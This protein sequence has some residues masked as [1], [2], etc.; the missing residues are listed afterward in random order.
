MV[1]IFSCVF[2]Q[3][4]ESLKC[5]NSSLP[6]TSDERKV[7]HHVALPFCFVPTKPPCPV[8]SGA[9]IMDKD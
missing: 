2:L 4:S 5:N 9:G 1:G 7:L 6:V 3:V 8:G